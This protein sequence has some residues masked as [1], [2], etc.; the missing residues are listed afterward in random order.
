MKD[1]KQTSKMKA[2]GSHYKSGGKVTNMK[3]G[4]STGDID[5]RNVTPAP[6][7]T[8]KGDS[9]VNVPGVGKVKSAP[10][11]APKGDSGIDVPGFG[12]VKPAAAEPPNAK[13]G[14]KLLKDGGKVKR[15][16]KKK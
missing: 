14:V 3:D 5:W 13:A 7:P 2:E 6:M 10:M 15:G 1:F 9:G 8:P 4:G 11:P 12:K 16:N